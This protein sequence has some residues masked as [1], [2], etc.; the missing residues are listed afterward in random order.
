MDHHFV[1]LPYTNPRKLSYHRSSNILH[2]ECSTRIPVAYWPLP[3]I[4]R[5]RVDMIAR[6]EIRL[7]DF[8][9]DL[10]PNEIEDEGNYVVDTG[11][12]SIM[13][14][15]V[16]A[17]RICGDDD[18][19]ISHEEPIPLLESIDEGDVVD[20]LITPM[21]DCH[22]DSLR[23]V[24]NLLLS[25][26]ESE[27]LGSTQDGDDCAISCRKGPNQMAVIL[28]RPSRDDGPFQICFIIGGKNWRRSGKANVDLL[29]CTSR[30][31]F[32]EQNSNGSQNLE[33]S[34]SCS[35]FSSGGHCQHYSA[36]FGKQELALKIYSMMARPVWLSSDIR[37]AKEWSCFK[38]P[39]KENEDVSVYQVFR[40][41]YLSST[42]RS[43]ASVIVDNKKN[44]LR[45]PYRYRVKCTSCAGAAGNRGLCVHESTCLEFFEDDETVDNISFENDDE[46][47]LDFVV[48]S[49]D[50][51]DS[52]DTL[53]SN[54][55]ASWIPRAFFSCVG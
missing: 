15:N 24:M 36:L 1:A 11:R 55:Y 9:T 29:S 26:I 19:L 42:I 14:K 27:S 22:G 28:L 49:D 13:E 23:A 34:C 37:S 39:R 4:L 54:E 31:S 21:N 12:Q 43:S 3:D 33:V 53:S 20:N 48:L 44:R 46:E 17:T 6:G 50:D 32:T 7:L 52:M 40:R 41:Q 16:V 8:Y 25:S 38:V 51:D 10:F 47:S 30:P 18:Y 45:M 2:D 5:N 35:M